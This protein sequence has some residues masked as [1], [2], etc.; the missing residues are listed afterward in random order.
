MNEKEAD[1]NFLI[2]RLDGR[3][4]H[5]LTEE[6]DVDR[7]FDLDFALNLVEAGKTIFHYS[8]R[9]MLAYAISDEVNFVFLETSNQGS[10]SSMDPALIERFS[11]APKCHSSSLGKEPALFLL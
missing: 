5:I 2:I 10:S 9:V 4:F 3:D 11:E 7:P 6:L 8:P 1:E